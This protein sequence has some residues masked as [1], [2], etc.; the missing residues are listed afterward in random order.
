[1]GYSEFYPYVTTDESGN[2]AGLAVQ[3]VQQA[4]ART[5]VTLQWIHV[6]DAEQALRSG[7]IDLFPLLTVTPERERDLYLSVPWWESSQ[8]LLSLRDRPLK[9]PAAASGK[10]IAIRDLAFGVPVAVQ[11]LPGASLVPTRDTK[12]MIAGVC[13]GQ[14]D[15]ALLDGRLIYEGLLDQPPACAGHRLLLVPVPQTTLPMATIS[16]RA[17]RPT[18]DRLSRP[19]PNWPSM[20]PSRT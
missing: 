7:Q 2:P 18:A 19:S 9:T 8:T 6:E 13:S 15:G 3:I 17:V 14:V 5:G 20:A 11:N 10:Q 16:T 1:M 4:A 12:K